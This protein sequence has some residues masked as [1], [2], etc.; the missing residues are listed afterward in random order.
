MANNRFVI[1]PA[2]LPSTTRITLSGGSH[3]SRTRICRI[4]GTVLPASLEVYAHLV[5]PD[6]S[7]YRGFRRRRSAR[8][9]WEFEFRGLPPREHQLTLIVRAWVGNGYV[10]YAET[11]ERRV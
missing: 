1:H 9:A 4:H 8:G 3:D 6:G 2:N 7:K 11:I 5:G 10:A